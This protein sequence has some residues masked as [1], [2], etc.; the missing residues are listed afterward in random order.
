MIGNILALAGM[1]IA[2]GLLVRVGWDLG[3]GSAEFLAFAAWSIVQ[4]VFWIA[5]LIVCGALVVLI[6]AV[7]GIIRL[8]RRAWGAI[9]RGLA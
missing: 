1:L 5:V 6:Y 3:Q 9:A 2:A 7:E 4:L 8:A